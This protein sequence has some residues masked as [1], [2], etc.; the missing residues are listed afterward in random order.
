[1]WSR[2]ILALSSVCI[3]SSAAEAQSCLRWNSYVSK[4]DYAYCGAKAVNSA[5]GWGMGRVVPGGNYAYKAGNYI[6]NYA[7]THPVQPKV[8]NPPPLRQ[9]Y[10]YSAPALPRQVQQYV[11]IYPRFRR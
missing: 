1:V 4:W 5:V 7:A 8:W 9:P 6:G 11:P 2:I 3:I 10:S